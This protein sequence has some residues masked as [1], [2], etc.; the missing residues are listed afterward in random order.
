MIREGCL[1]TLVVKYIHAILQQCTEEPIP[2]CLQ[3]VKK[4]KACSKPQKRSDHQAGQPK[5]TCGDGLN[6]TA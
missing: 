6:K 3:F 4:N 1:A 2:G 5:V